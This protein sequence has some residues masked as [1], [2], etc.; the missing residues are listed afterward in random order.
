[1]RSGGLITTPDSA[2]SRG[3]CQVGLWTILSRTLIRT[4]R[5][6]PIVMAITGAC[7]S[8][9][10]WATVSVSYPVSLS[11]CADG[12]TIMDGIWNVEG[13]IFD[14]SGL[15][16]FGDDSTELKEHA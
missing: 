10:I 5:R 9:M 4:P 6:L 2:S 13:S 7:A 15:A 8:I 12:G 14:A 1:M 16:F 3:P 11:E